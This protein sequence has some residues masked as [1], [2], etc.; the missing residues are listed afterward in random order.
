MSKYDMLLAFDPPGQAVRTG[1]TPVMYS[2]VACHGFITNRK[3]IQLFQLF[4]SPK[5]VLF[6]LSPNLYGTKMHNY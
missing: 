6:P 5:E 3:N 1:R 4:P 2:R